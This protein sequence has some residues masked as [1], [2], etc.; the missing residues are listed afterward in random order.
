MKI[1][2]SLYRQYYNPLWLLFYLN[3]H[4]KR[5]KESNIHFK[6]YYYKKN[7]VIYVNH[8]TVVDN[9]NPPW[10]LLLDCFDMFC[11]FSNILVHLVNALKIFW[12]GGS[13]CG[14][15]KVVI[16]NTV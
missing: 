12:K 7:F 9:T 8:S 2:F 10:E 6:S 13:I 11:L 1:L 5:K 15:L 14:F 3:G 4:N 16:C